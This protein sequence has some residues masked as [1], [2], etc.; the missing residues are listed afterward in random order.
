LL[1]AAPRAAGRLLERVEDVITLL[2]DFPAAGRRR[3]G[4][5]AGLRSFRVRGY[6]YVV[7][8][9]I[10]KNDVIMVRL[11]HGAQRIRRSLFVQ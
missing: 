2:A 5:A 10:E 9:L 7:Y 8:Y 6:P 4:L 3:R 1:E 11:L